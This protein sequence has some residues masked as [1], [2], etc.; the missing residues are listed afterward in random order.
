MIS[1]RDTNAMN[2]ARKTG[3]GGH[4]RGA[5]GKRHVTNTATLIEGEARRVLTRLDCGS[6]TRYGGDGIGFR[7]WGMGR[8]RPA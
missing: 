4:C 1:A 3:G 6:G 2:V 5:I 7:T 8:H